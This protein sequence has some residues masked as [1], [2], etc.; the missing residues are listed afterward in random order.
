MNYPARR[1]VDKADRVQLA[2]WYRHLPSPGVF[3]PDK[4][5]QEKRTLDRILE[6]FH[7][8]GGFDPGLSK[9]VGW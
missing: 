6:R 2:L 1:D 4:E 8:L 7:K 3:N 5:K 9:Y